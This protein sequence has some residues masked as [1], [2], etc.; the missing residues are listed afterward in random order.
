MRKAGEDVAVMKEVLSVKEQQLA[1]AQKVSSDLLASITAST[2]KAEK[3]K[4][5]I[6]TIKVKCNT[7]H[8]QHAQHLHMH[9]TCTCTICTTMDVT[10]NKSAKIQQYLI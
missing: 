1:K 10:Y 4:A 9:N 2:S 3:K 5:E 6:T 7:Q 8:A